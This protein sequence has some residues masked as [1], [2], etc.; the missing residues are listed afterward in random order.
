LTLKDIRRHKDWL[1]SRMIDIL[2]PS[3]YAVTGDS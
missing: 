1:Q 2:P 3:S